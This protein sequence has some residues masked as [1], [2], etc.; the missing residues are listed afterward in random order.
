MGCL[1]ADHVL[2]VELLTQEAANR[3]LT[4]SRFA[5]DSMVFDDNAKV[6]ETLRGHGFICFNAVSLNKAAA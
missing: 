6:L 2:K 5:F 3:G 1:D 4:L